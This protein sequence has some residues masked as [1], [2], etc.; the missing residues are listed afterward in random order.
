M[1]FSSVYMTTWTTFDTCTSL[2]SW[3]ELAVPSLVWDMALF[4]GRH[5]KSGFGVGSTVFGTFGFLGYFYY[6]GLI[7]YLASSG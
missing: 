6:F 1:V 5:S 2:F 4:L 7:I 3:F